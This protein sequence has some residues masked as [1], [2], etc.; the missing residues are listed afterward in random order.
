MAENK[1]LLEESEADQTPVGEA[2]PAAETAGESEP[3]NAEQEAV[4]EEAAE[5]MQEK[6][7][8]E[9]EQVKKKEQNAAPVQ[10]DMSDRMIGAFTEDWSDISAGQISP[11]QRFRE[12]YSKALHLKQTKG[13][14]WVKV[15]GVETARTGRMII[16]TSLYDERCVIPESQFWMPGMR[17]RRNYD[18]LSEEAKEAV[19]NERARQMLGAIIPITVEGVAK[20]HVADD[21]DSGEFEHDEMTAAGSRVNGMKILQDY[22][23]WHQNGREGAEYGSVQRGDLYKRA[24]VLSV[25]ENSIFVEAFGVETTIQM[26]DLTMSCFIEN[27]H[28]YYHA[29]DTLPVVKVI[30]ASARKTPEETR[31]ILDLSVRQA[32]TLGTV[33][34]YRNIQE[35]G[36]YLGRVTHISR[37]GKYHILLQTGV[38]CVVSRENVAKLITLNPGDM[39][40]VVITGKNDELRLCYGYAQ[41]I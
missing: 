36:I 37:T 20:N 19:R 10:E 7:E 13:L 9:P 16:V 33:Q 2:L 34:G 6:P 32:E 3:Q 4:K 40:N 23:F 22:W 28:D 12:H 14:A 30:R 35:R 8:Q 29:G 11:E 26:R 39:V 18:G 25:S 41:K 31:I 38:P 5:T 21:P 27:C 1:K 15:K 17:F 24:H